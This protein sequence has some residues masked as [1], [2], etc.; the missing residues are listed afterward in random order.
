MMMF[1]RHPE[2]RPT[3]SLYGR[4]ET[5]RNAIMKWYQI[6][7][8][9]RLS[10]STELDGYLA[11]GFRGKNPLAEDANYAKEKFARCGLSY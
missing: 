9:K 1:T 8:T 10:A 4:K 3:R 7:L 6:L 11:A 2:F 5:F